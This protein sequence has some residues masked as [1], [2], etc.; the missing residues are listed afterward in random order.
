MAA[1]AIALEEEN[2]H[3]INASLLKL[4]LYICVQRN[5]ALRLCF[6]DLV[7]YFVLLDIHLWKSYYKNYSLQAQW[8]LV[9]IHLY[10]VLVNI[11]QG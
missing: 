6:Y 2:G 7:R 11:H 5:H 9:N 1:I 4:R 3:P 10:F 8:A